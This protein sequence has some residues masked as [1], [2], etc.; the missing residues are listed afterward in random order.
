MLPVGIDMLQANGNRKLV[1]LTNPQRNPEL[2]ET[3]R[4]KLSIEDPDP[5]EWAV[6]IVP[7]G[8]GP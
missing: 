1:R 4:R 2:D 7:W 5:A 6:S 3:A 8:E